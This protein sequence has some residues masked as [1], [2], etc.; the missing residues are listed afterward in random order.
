M[1]MMMEALQHLMY[2]QSGFYSD[3]SKEVGACLYKIFRKKHMSF[4]VAELRE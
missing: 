1:T 3:S 2:F 4:K